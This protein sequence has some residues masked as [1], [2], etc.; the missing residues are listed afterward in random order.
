MQEEIK[1]KE[2]QALIDLYNSCNGENWIHNENWLSSK[3]VNQWFGV[4]T[5]DGYV[6]QL[7]LAENNLCGELPGSIGDFMFLEVLILSENKLTGHIPP[8]VRKW[9][10]VDM[11]LLDHNDLC[12]RVP[13]SVQ[14]W[15]YLSVFF[16]GRNPRL[17]GPCPKV[18]DHC[19]IHVDSTGIGVLPC[20]STMTIRDWRHEFILSYV[21][22]EV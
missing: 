21:L 17:C 15:E 3:P 13:V 10:F 2:R 5:E 19:V 4:F 7:C 20:S 11:V 6:S 14:N 22:L 12:G 16:I 18:S 9:R 1:E 8:S